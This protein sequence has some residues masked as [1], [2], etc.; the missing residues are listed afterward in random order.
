M[1]RDA[2]SAR[3]TDSSAVPRLARRPL[4]PGGNEVFT[5]APDAE[6]ATRGHKL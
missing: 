1:T 2:V 5:E 3:V 4:G 6:T